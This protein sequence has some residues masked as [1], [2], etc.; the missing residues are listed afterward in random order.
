MKYFFIFL[1]GLILIS[2]TANA[3]DLTLCG[4]VKAENIERFRTQFLKAMPKECKTK[5]PETMNVCATEY[6][7]AEWIQKV[8]GDY[9]RRVIKRADEM[10]AQNGITMPSDYETII[11]PQGE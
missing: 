11:R 3:Q 9:M 1:T 6:T 7:D 10:D 5:E 2:A 8:T 4:V